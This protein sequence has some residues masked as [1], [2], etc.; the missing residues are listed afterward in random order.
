[1]LQPPHHDF[2][3]GVKVLSIWVHC[4]VHP[5]RQDDINKAYSEAIGEQASNLLD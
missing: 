1:M 3:E 5:V 2:V 4:N